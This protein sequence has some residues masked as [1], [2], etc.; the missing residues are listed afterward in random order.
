[1]HESLTAEKQGRAAAK[2]AEGES[3]ERQPI[4]ANY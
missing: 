2:N 4:V 1:M 3:V